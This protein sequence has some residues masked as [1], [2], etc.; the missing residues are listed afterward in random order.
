M[1]ICPNCKSEVEDSAMICPN[2]GS[3]KMVQPAK[4]ETSTASAPAEQEKKKITSGLDW[5]VTAHG[6]IAGIL[7]LATVIYF[8]IGLD[9]SSYKGSIYFE[10]ALICLALGFSAL[11]CRYLVK[12]FGFIVKAAKL[13][14]MN[15]GEKIEE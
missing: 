4:S 13:Y 1:W 12:G 8:F 2:C 15:N 5:I 7:F 14:L 11:F 3:S 6:I 10:N 9:S